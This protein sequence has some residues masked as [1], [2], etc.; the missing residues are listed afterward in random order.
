MWGCTVKTIDDIPNTKLSPRMWG[1]TESNHRESLNQK[2]VPT[3][4]GVYRQAIDENEKRSNC[5]HVCGG[6]PRYHL[7]Y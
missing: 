7:I 5:P 6:V 2:I 4:V 1:C 3:Y